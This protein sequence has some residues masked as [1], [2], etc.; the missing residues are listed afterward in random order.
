MAYPQIPHFNAP[1]ALSASGAAVVDQ[2]SPEEILA[3]VNNIVSCPIDFRVEL[4]NFGIPWPQF[5]E[6]PVPFAGIAQAV[7]L[8]EPRAQLS[9]VEQVLSTID[10]ER[11]LSITVF[12][13]TTD[14]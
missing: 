10:Q 13:N 7:L 6:A 8:W 12:T 5:V 2:N 14:N 3:C 1:F 4:P 9:A 11:E